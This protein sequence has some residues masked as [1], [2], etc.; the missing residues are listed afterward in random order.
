[1]FFNDPRT[2]R[3][4]GDRKRYSV[5]MVTET[6]NDIVKLLSQLRNPP[7]IHQL[8]GA[9]VGSSTLQDGYIHAPYCIIRSLYILHARSSRTD[10]HGLAGTRDM[11]QL[12]TL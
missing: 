9:G 5:L 8:R 11:A 7:Q 4:G 12:A 1:M 10:K 2:K 6:D 3:I